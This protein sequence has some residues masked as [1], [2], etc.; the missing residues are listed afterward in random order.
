[1]SMDVCISC[2][3]ELVIMERN[4]SECWECRDKTT[5]SYEEEFVEE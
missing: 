1:M 5:E 3:N 4:R 2:G